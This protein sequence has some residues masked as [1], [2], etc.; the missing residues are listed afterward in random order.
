MA[1][2]NFLAVPPGVI[3]YTPPND[4]LLEKDK[5]PQWFV[6]QARWIISCGYNQPRPVFTSGATIGNGI[7]DEALE[8]WSFIFAEQAN[9]TF[10]YIQQDFSGNTVPAVFIP[11]GK[12]A[13]LFNHIK[14]RLISD[15]Q[16][17]EVSAKNL[18]REVSSKRSEMLEKLVLKYK[19]GK[20]LKEAMPDAVEFNPMGGEVEGLQS[21]DEIE[22]YVTKW[23][24][25]FTILVERMAAYLM[26][27]DFLKDKFVSQGAEQMAGGVSGMLTQ[28]V[29]G[30]VTNESIPSWKLIWDNR[31][32]DDFNREAWFC[33]VM[34]VKVPYQQVIQQFGDD[35]SEEE[36]KEIRALADNQYLQQA[37]AW[38]NYYNTTATGSSPVW[39]VNPGTIDMC[40]SYARVWWIGPRDFRYKQTY[41]K[42]GTPR[43]K[44][45]NDEEYYEKGYPKKLKGSDI[46]G[47]FI[48]YDLHTGI[49]IGNKYLVRHGYANNVL[50]PLGNR[51]RPSLPINILCSGMALGGNKPLVS[52]LK[53]NQREIDRLA[54]K[55][56][57]ITGK[58]FGKVFI[59]NGNK[60]DVTSTELLS[61][62]KI[63]GIH[64]SRGGSGESDDPSI[65]QPMVE[66]VD[67]TL[68][69]NIVRYIDLKNE[70]KREMDEIASVSQISLGQQGYTVGK[71][72]QQN[73]INQNSF[74]LAPM[75]SGLMKHYERVLQYNVDLQ[76]LLWSLSDSFDE[77]MIIGDDGSRLLELID[78]KEFGTQ[79]MKVNIKLNDPTDTLQKDRIQS[80]ALAAAQNQ[81]L[82][83]IDYVEH[84]E[85]ADTSTQM[86][87]GLK[88]SIEKRERQA[89]EAQ[90]MAN[91]S[92]MQHEASLAEQKAINEAMLIQT[93][94]NSANWREALK[95]IAKVTEDIQALA[96]MMATAPAQ[97]PM[98][99]QMEQINEAQQQPAPPI[100]EPIPQ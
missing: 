61:D 95:A 7:V 28:T 52:R 5:T 18:S 84:V 63:M 89:M 37:T 42:L 59:I 11:G 65:N 67:M 47:D 76:Q 31:Q 48:G 4:Y 75:I 87:K 79:R 13:E 71:G 81:Q 58:A 22:K 57:E 82:S 72:V 80:V 100:Q 16:N 29:N 35:L 90:A 69:P 45:I 60:L 92:A 27:F 39:W 96:V 40:I 49:L 43:Y 1:D 62:M 97:S 78:P 10:A 46:P 73:T 74:G 17:L 44:K 77:E 56:Q 21:L 91:N 98:L 15:I 51:E 34:E 38:F 9:D 93:K 41:D 32:D 14:G 6:E 3:R 70:Q 20:L 85:F 8:N 66:V 99:T 19:Y 30:R 2:T 64:V 94:E 23:Q 83:F 33:G 50:R 55:I 88:H 26:E 36:I 54:F 12:I 25:R 53:A 24:D 86:L 68:D